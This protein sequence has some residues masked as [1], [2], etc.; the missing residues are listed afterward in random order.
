MHLFFIKYEK[1]LLFCTL[2]KIVVRFIDNC[3]KYFYG[4]GITYYV[5]DTRVKNKLVKAQTLKDVTP[6]KK[7]VN[8]RVMQ[9]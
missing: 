1:M 3:C 8:V 9:C 6:I 5:D 2:H 4:N 7:L